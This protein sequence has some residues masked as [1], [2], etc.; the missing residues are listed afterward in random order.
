MIGCTVIHLSVSFC[1]VYDNSHV[2]HNYTCVCAMSCIIIAVFDS[3]CIKIYLILQL[4]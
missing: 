4:T 3:D 1:P 2:T